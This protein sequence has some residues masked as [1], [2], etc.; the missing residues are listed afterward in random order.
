[1]GCEIKTS[2]DGKYII[3]IVT[4]DLTGKLMMEYNLKSH[5]L[6][7]ELDINRFLVDV[8]KSRNVDPPTKNFSFARYDL[9]K[10]PGIDPSA[11]VAAIVS[12]G[13]KSH[14]FIETV[15]Q[16]RGQDITLFTDRRQAI[17]Y[18]LKD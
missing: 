13:D 7:R 4:G 3:Q 14:D 1:M 5:A 17:R 9:I 6:G 11:R 8:T 12:P 16:D 15:F 18:L 10:N 2:E